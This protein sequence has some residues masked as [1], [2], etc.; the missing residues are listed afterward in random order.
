MGEAPH[1]DAGLLNLDPGGGGHRRWI[2]REHLGEALSDYKVKYAIY[3]PIVQVN[4]GDTLY[5]F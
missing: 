1:G 5:H 3:V 4:K 2:F